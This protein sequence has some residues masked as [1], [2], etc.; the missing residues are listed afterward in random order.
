MAK[1]KSKKAMGIDNI[2]SKLVTDCASV[3]RGA[4]CVYYKPITMDVNSSIWLETGE[5]YSVFHI[6]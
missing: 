4:S 2:A 6:R 5:S 3:T 1:N